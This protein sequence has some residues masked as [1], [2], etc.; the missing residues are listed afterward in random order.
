LTVVRLAAYNPPLRAPWATQTRSQRRA[1]RIGCLLGGHRHASVP[2]SS[3]NCCRD[4]R[5]T[6]PLGTP[7]RA[8]GARGASEPRNVQT[9][10]ADA[11]G[12]DER[13]LPERN[14]SRRPYEAQLSCLGHPEVVPSPR[15]IQDSTQGQE[16]PSADAHVVEAEAPTRDGVSMGASS[17]FWHFL[18]KGYRHR[19]E[20]CR[21]ESGRQ[22]AFAPSRRCQVPIGSPR[23]SRALVESQRQCHPEP[24]IRARAGI[25]SVLWTGCC[26]G[27]E[28][29]IRRSDRLYLVRASTERSSFQHYEEFGTRVVGDTALDSRACRALLDFSRHRQVELGV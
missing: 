23:R 22:A 12:N 25:S 21:S 18:Q 7:D 17:S 24:Q 4:P 1:A 16:R 28:R 26:D 11:S 15:A 27:F 10:K 14:L 9:H 3:H 20:V 8:R 5:F 2:A 19:R 29:N 6:G 13:D